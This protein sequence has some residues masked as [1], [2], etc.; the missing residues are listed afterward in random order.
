MMCKADLQKALHDPTRIQQLTR[1][2]IKTKRPE[3][4]M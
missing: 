4:L 3:R 1:L 2:A